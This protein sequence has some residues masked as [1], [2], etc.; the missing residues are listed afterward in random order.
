MV[1]D[2]AA[3]GK[4]TAKDMYGARGWMAHHNTDI[5]RINGAVDGAFWGIWPNGGGWLSQHLWEHY[6]YSGDKNY[7]ASIYP[8]L[9]GAAMFYSDYLIEHPKYHWLVV[10]PDM[11]PEN[12]PAAHQHSSLDAGVTMTNQIVFDVFTNAIDAAKILNK[13]KAFADTLKQKRSQLAP[14]HIGQYGQLQEW[15]D[16]VDDP[17]DHHRHISHLYGLFPSN[18]ISPYRTPQLYSAA[19]NTLIQRGDVSTGWSMGWKVNWWAKMLDGNHAYK[20]IQ[21][22]LTPCW[23]R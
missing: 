17:N 4:K 20:L 16:D 5:W 19:K 21:N 15:L 6:L 12:A 8:V 7:L 14:M 22:Q 23:P 18:Q 3:T 13:D 9:K 11:S 2:L 1:E 10:C